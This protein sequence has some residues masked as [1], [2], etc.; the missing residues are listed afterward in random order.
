MKISIITRCT[1]TQNLEII[2][3]SIFNNVPNGFNLTWHILFDTAVIKDIDAELLSRLN[4]DN[5]SLIHI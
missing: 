5:L 1:R 4:A 2:K 3:E